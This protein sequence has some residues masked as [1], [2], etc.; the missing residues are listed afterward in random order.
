MTNTVIIVAGGRGRRMGRD[1]PKQFLILDGIPVIMH[2]LQRFYQYDNCMKIILVLPANEIFTWKN[3]CVE[4][5]FTIPHQTVEGGE[6]RFHSVK[7]ALKLTGENEIVAIHDGVRPLVSGK[8]IARCFEMAEKTG[9]AVPVVEI[10]ESLRYFE[11]PDRSVSVNRKNYMTVQTPQVFKSEILVAAYAQ[12]YS[13]NFTDDA[14]VVE[15]SGHLITT[16]EGNRENIKIT[17]PVDMEIA[18]ILIEQRDFL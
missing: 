16:V 6:E 17:N 4:H 2:T 8:T 5:K 18:K 15:K 11:S 7:N 3:L 12:A 9:A 1:I 10:T 13:E 14:S